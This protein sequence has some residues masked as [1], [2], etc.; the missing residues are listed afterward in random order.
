MSMSKLVG[1]TSEVKIVMFFTFL[2]LHQL[3]S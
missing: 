1:I 3:E 2:G